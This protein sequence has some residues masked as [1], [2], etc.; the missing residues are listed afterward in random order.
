MNIPSRAGTGDFPPY[1]QGHAS[2]G[3]DGVQA[4]KLPASENWYPPLPS[5]LAAGAEA[6]PGINRYPQMAV[7]ELART[8]ARRWSFPATPWGPVPDP[9]KPPV[10]WPN[11]NSRNG[12]TDST[13]GSWTPPDV[14]PA[15]WPRCPEPRN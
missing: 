1:R 3:T 14:L 2:R 12:S 13:T 4:F 10:R 15:C 6:L 9:L 8:I 5:V 11:P 7:E